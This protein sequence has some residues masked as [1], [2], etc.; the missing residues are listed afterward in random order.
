MPAIY[1]TSKIDQQ[2][3]CKTN[4]QFT[5]HLRNHDLTYR[6]GGMTV[7]VKRSIRTV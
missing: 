2:R 4:G 1:A 5:R 7:M 3:Y 6:R